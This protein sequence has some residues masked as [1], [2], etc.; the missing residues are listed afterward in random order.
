MAHEK[1]FA[2]RWSEFRPSKTIWFWS[3]AG[4]AVLTMIVGFT[5]GGWTTGGTAETMA[6]QVARDARAELA[7]VVCVEKFIVAAGAAGR[8]A[9]LQETTGYQQD[10]FI[11]DGGWATMVG[12]EDT[13]PGAADLCA[14]TLTAMES[15]PVRDVTTDASSTDS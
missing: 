6:A 8:L 15:L 1:G 13:I 4:A 2:D 11:E 3:S 9:E 14:D 12:M 5:A 7:S 10:D